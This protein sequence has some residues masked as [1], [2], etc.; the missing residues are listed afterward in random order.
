[1]QHTVTFSSRESET[2]TL[3][4]FPIHMFCQNLATN[5]IATIFTDKTVLKLTFSGTENGLTSPQTLLV[6]HYKC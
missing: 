1:M 2:N 6:I 5:V 4:T 3:N